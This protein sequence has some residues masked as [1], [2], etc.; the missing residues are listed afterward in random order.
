MI[1]SKR[2]ERLAI[3][4][5]FFISEFTSYQNVV[6]G[7]AMLFL[8][9]SWHLDTLNSS[10]PS[11]PSTPR[12]LDTST[13]RH[14]DTLRFTLTPIGPNLYLLL[15]WAKRIRQRTPTFHFAKYTSSLCRAITYA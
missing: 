13:P 8:S 3:R 7:K 9:A 1:Q 2:L 14:L 4:E 12:H 6:S 15:F 11:T 5:L 10:T